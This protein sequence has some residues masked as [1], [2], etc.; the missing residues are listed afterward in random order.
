MQNT[1]T[2]TYTRHLPGGR[3]VNNS[4]T[5]SFNRLI[6]QGA[7]GGIGGSTQRRGIDAFTDENDRNVNGGAGTYFGLS[8]NGGYSNSY[9][10]WA[11][12]DA[13]TI[14]IEVYDKTSLNTA[15]SSLT[16]RYREL[17]NGGLSITNAS[18]YN[19]LVS[20]ANTMLRTREVT[21]AD[22]ANKTSELNSFV[23]EIAAPGATASWTY[24]SVT[25][26]NA[27]NT[28]YNGYKSS[29]MNISVS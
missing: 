19:T 7:T 13:A 24:G 11:Y 17:S 18:A 10:G 2:G 4:S 14:S 20:G 6:Y 3:T 26:A 21:A 25:A 12:R 9:A 29:V 22:V 23:F 15:I 8:A 16:S 28:V 1:G 27:V 5:Q